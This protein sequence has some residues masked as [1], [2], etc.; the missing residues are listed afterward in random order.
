MIDH[1]EKNGNEKRKKKMEVQEKL[2]KLPK[3]YGFF[4]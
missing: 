4:F 3:M 1:V 2:L